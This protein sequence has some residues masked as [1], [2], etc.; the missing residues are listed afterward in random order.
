MI[1]TILGVALGVA[2]AFCIVAAELLRAF[3]A[4]DGWR[5]VIAAVLAACGA[6]V[7]LTGMFH[8]RAHPETDEETRQSL[9]FK[10]GRP[11]WGAML[12]AGAGIALFIQ[13]LRTKE[14]AVA[15]P[16]PARPVPPV[17]VKAAPPTVTNAPVK[18]PALKIQGC[19]MVGDQPVVLINGEA[20]G[21][22]DQV[23]GVTVKS[24]TREGALMELGS[25]TKLYKV[26]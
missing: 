17:V 10:L 22:G 3:P 2:G 12:L 13:P 18:F 24:V 9:S 8:R 5:G 21:V 11:F 20:F 6:T 26:Q 1:W 7:G 14:A 23:Q 19:I 4:L 16:P 15:P 25:E